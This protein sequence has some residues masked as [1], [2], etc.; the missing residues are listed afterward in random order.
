MPLA[1]LEELEWDEEA[2][3]NADDTFDTSSIDAAIKALDLDAED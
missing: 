3:E 1:E 2:F